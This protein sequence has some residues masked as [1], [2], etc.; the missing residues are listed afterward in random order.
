[1][2]SIRSYPNGA[3]GTSGADL[4]VL[5]GI[6]TS[7]TVYY[8][9]NAVSGN[10]DSNGGTERDVPWATLAH[11]VATV[12]AGDT[13]VLL[14]SHAET[15]SS[16]IAISTAHLNI[17]GEGSGTTVPRLTNGVAAG[18]NPMITL[19]ALNLLMDNV[20]F[21]G[22]SVAA[23]ARIKIA[24]GGSIN[25]RNASFEMSAN[26]AVQG[27]WWVSATGGDFCDNLT[28]TKT[29][30]GAGVGFL[31]NAVPNITMGTVTFDGGSFGAFTGGSVTA[32]A[33][34]TKIRRMYL[35]N[36]ST[37]LLA[38]GSTGFVQ[39]AGSTGDSRVDWT[40]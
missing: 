22:S 18:T 12:S 35:L 33:A 27:L 15:I 2:A 20:Y 6:Y 11:A 39:V 34:G 21:P 25:L 38:T 32:G 13:V 9:G 4:A 7:G 31:I 5:K 1:M 19:T 37:M 29:A 10:S 3:G 40:V 24:A 14:A 16:N 36:G 28:F 30:A 26:D 17:V 23:T 8:V